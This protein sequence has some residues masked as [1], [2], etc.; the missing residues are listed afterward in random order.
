[1][2]APQVSV[3]IIVH[4]RAHTIGA[5]VRSVLAQ[6]FSD[7]ELIV[8]DDG[9]TD[10]TTA[11]V[12]GFGDP[13]LRLI[14]TSR[15]QGIPLARNRALSEA[16][17]R[18]IAW[19]DSDDLC[20][21]ERLAVQRDVLLQCPHLAM[22]GSGARKIRADGTLMK[23]ARVPVRTHE[24]IRALLL[25]RSA[26]QQSSIFGR[27][28]ALR[29]VPYD[30]D[31]SVCED[32]DMFVRLT[33][34]Y[35]AANLPNFLIARRL[36]G[37]QTVRKKV[38]IIHERQGAISARLLD[39]LGLSVGPADLRRHVLLG[40]ADGELQTDALLDWAEAWM[41][42]IEEANR[43]RP[44]FAPIALRSCLERLLIKAAVRRV[45]VEPSTLPAFVRRVARHRAG[46]AR[47]VMEAAE[48]LLPFAGRPSASG[49][50]QV[51]ERVG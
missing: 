7:F 22:I 16:R 50:R 6:T 38:E 43:R 45:T 33:E 34:R 24:E 20:H 30:P 14:R 19:L 12:E 39:R 18:F 17:G 10:E 28:E 21:P 3:L 11:V 41:A 26:F 48:G 29:E 1:M 44:L 4:N 8:V 2:D 35:R 25:F 51:L 40:K 23:A 5:A 27:V 49:I 47:L 15:N 9:S 42:K 31:F 46:T 36:H 13:R 32:V 37:G